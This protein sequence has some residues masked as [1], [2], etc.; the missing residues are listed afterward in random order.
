MKVWLPF[1]A[2]HKVPVI[3]GIESLVKPELD[4][5]TY[6]VIPEPRA[7]GEQAAGLIIDLKEKNWKSDGAIVYPAIS[8]YSVLNMK[9]AVQITDA[10]S[11]NFNEVIRVLTDEK[12]DDK[13]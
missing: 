10:K 8:V 7:M 4:F 11:I 12:D 1:F 3:V 6:A 2:T 5:G 13:R 9:K